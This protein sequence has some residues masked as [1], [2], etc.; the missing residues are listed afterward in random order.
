M[1]KP[2]FS[3]VTITPGT[4]AVGESYLIVVVV[5]D[6][7]LTIEKANAMTLT[8]IQTVTLDRMPNE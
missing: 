5:E 7:V 3:A 8:Q 2:E 1:R 6:P 4:V